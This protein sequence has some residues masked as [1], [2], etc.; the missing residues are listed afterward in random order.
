MTEVRRNPD[1]DE[2]YRQIRTEIHFELSLI[3]A[4]V[5]WLVTSQAFLFVPLTLGARST[6]DL[7]SSVF[8]PAIPMLGVAICVLVMVSVIAAVWRGNQ[9]RRK[10]RQGD[11]DGSRNDRTFDPIL[12][13]KPLIPVLGLVGGLGVPVVLVMTWLW[14]LVSPPGA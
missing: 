2:V 3:N 13:H 11:Y 9:W 14:L 7:S 6:G 4:R 8:Y 5:N 12:P 10:A 1:N